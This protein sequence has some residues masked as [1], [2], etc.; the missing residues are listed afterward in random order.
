MC[1]YALTGADYG[2]SV[3]FAIEKWQDGRTVQQEVDDLGIVG[4][5]GAR[6]QQPAPDL[7]PDAVVISDNSS[8]AVVWKAGDVQKIYVSTAADPA[9]IRTTVLNVARQ[10]YAAEQG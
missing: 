3:A 5:D 2:N 4:S 9:G 1:E 10:I 7:G 8:I 6:T